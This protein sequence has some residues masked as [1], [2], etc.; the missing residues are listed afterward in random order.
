MPRILTF[1]TLLI[2]FLLPLSAMAQGIDVATPTAVTDQNRT[3]KI[4]Y[5]AS[6][7]TEVESVDL[8]TGNLS[9][10]IPLVHVKG[11]G[12]DY[13]ITLQYDGNYW[14]PMPVPGNNSSIW[15]NETRTYIPNVT[16]WSLSQPYITFAIGVP[17]FT[18][19]SEPVPPKNGGGQGSPTPV[20]A[21]G[22]FYYDYIFVDGEGRKNPLNVNNGDV[23]C[24]GEIGGK[25]PAD[26]TNSGPDTNAQGIWA[27]MDQYVANPVRT[28]NGTIYAPGGSAPNNPTTTVGGYGL[29]NVTDVNANTEELT[30]GGLDTIGRTPLTLTQD[31]ATQFHYTYYDPNG[32][33]QQIVVHLE[34]VN[35]TTDFGVDSTTGYPIFE[36][37]G[38]IQTI[39]SIDLP[40][41]T[42]YAFTYENNT[43]GGLT[44]ITLP[45]G[46]SVS[47]QYATVLNNDWSHRYVT[48]RTTNDG[49]T[50]AIWNLSI[51]NTTSN[52]TITNA[53]P[54][55]LSGYYA[56]ISTLTDPTAQHN[57]SV[58]TQT[59]GFTYDVKVYS[60]TA[61]GNPLRHYQ[62]AYF[63][64]YPLPQ[65]GT[66]FPMLNYQGLL[67]SQIVTTNDA[68]QVSEIQYDYDSFTYSFKDC[69][70]GGPSSGCLDTGM[71][72]RTGNAT[73]GNVTGIREYDWGAGAPGALLRQ[74]LKTYAYSQNAGYVGTNVVDR[75][76]SDSVYD[77]SQVCYGGQ[78]CSANLISQTTY[79]Y[80]QDGVGYLGRLTETSKWVN[81]TNSSLNTSYTYDGHGNITSLTD[82]DGNI[83]KWSY[84]DSW[85]SNNGNCV[86][87]QN[88]SSY[89]TSATNP[90]GQT[91]SY[92]Y[93][94]CT[95][96]PVT[97]Q[98]PNDTAAKRNGLQVAYD[99][100]DRITDVYAADGGHK[101]TIYDDKA[102]TVETQTYLTSSNTVNKLTVLDGLGRTKETELLSDPAGTDYVTTTYDLMG[103]TWCVSNPYR[104][105]SNGSVCTVYDALSRPTVVTEQDGSSRSN[106]YS[107]YVTTETDENGN[108]WAR[109]SDAL[110]RLK[111]VVEPGSLKTNYTYDVLGDLLTVSQLGNSSTDTTR[112]RSFTYDSLSRLISSTNAETG[113][114]SYQY[115]T[116]A[117][118]C[119]GDTSLPCSKTDARGITTNY[120]YDT[121]NRLLSKTY[122]ND[123]TGTASSCYQ[124]DGTSATNSIGRLI[125]QWTQ[126]AS[127]GAC[128]ATL[129]ASGYLTLHSILAYDPMGRIQSE[130]QCT[131]SNCATNTPYNPTYNYDLAGNILTYGNG[132]GTMTFT[133]CY[134]T[135]GHLLSVVSVSTTCPATLSPSTTLFSTPAYNPAGALTGATLGTGLQLS[136][137]YDTRLRVTGETDTG[138]ASAT[139]PGSATLTISGSEQM[140]Q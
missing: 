58:Y 100:M 52:I 74:T 111:N 125:Y 88:Q 115:T 102:Q 66:S 51:A 40:N 120:S 14:T 29:A 23:V 17:N 41:G 98:D 5:S 70:P 11:R 93:A 68:G 76:A 119:A 117:A 105:Q 26:Y 127:S 2:T 72:T 35:I 3:G 46:G 56:T 134:D 114:I 47:Y 57:Q 129:P 31:N 138:N 131:Q 90:M 4:P 67:P 12:L 133:N 1:S 54:Q 96:Q 49:I 82:P 33:P 83:S 78:T 13:D 140:Q 63:G 65:I 132:M 80:D 139:T 97:V 135:A 121:L 43:F 77:G 28:A 48:Q 104:S 75:V 85:A 59:S 87:S 16:G 53:N 38:S 116:N 71:V 124:Y 112:T 61:T 130:Q 92:T 18:C 39:Q 62:I 118:L 37:V 95:G 10:R 19:A 45:N 110:G 107:G 55:V 21:S 94:P 60:G 79:S 6:M 32:N 106:Y 81:S 128:K 122:T 86:P 15:A 34:T 20:Q 9:I 109:T 103:R 108:S 101:K 30:P 27:T 69:G 24:A 44:S 42:S 113:T 36:A 126:K 50:Q 84:T 7:G 136:R 25:G 64:Y 123:T 8:S 99:L 137:S 91:T 73:R 89:M 22:K